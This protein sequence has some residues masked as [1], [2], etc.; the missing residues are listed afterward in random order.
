MKRILFTMLLLFVAGLVKAQIENPV[1]WAAGAKK[2]SNTE[3]II[4]LK[5]TIDDG[6]HI[7][8][9]KKND[10]GGPVSTRFTFT[11]SADYTIVGNT[12]EPE[13]ITRFE[14]S[15]SMN[16]S[17]YEHSVI[18]Q[19]KIKLNKPTTVVKGTIKFMVCNDEKCLPPDTIPFTAMVK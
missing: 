11:P 2:I 4:M 3:A 17:F 6:W 15:F 1:K 7:Y 16:L 19:Q 12:A 14:E 10:N 5:A 18:F 9:Q 13:P 8:S